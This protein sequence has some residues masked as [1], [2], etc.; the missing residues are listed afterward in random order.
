MVRFQCERSKN[1]QKANILDGSRN[2]DKRQKESLWLDCGKLKS[3][4]ST[5]LMVWSKKKT[6]LFYFLFLQNQKKYAEF[7]YQECK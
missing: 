6:F 5:F 7:F 2:R 3:H 4:Q 1:L